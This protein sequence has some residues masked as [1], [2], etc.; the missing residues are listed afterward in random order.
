MWIAKWR[1]ENIWRQDKKSCLKMECYYTG[2]DQVLWWR[3]RF[4][5][6]WTWLGHWNPNWG[7]YWYRRCLYTL[8]TNVVKV[9]V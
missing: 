6:N 5:E 9:E 4:V 7:S 8:P 3:I 2:K 1:Y